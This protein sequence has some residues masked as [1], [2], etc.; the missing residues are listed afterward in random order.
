MGKTLRPTRSG[1]E[2]VTSLRAL[3]ER[4][5]A[6]WIVDELSTRRGTKNLDL[7]DFAVL[8]RTNA[9][10]RALEEALRRHTIQYRLVGSVRFY[11]RREIRDLMSYLK[12]IAIPAY[13]EDFRRVIAISQRGRGELTL[14]TLAEN[15]PLA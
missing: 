13:D 2:P 4:D 14:D 1:S 7:R 10:S 11:D 5:E 6:E 12:L 15:V 9:Q 3:D 8:Y